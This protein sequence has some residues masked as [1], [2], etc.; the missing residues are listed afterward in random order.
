MAG[1]REGLLDRVCDHQT[2]APSAPSAPQTQRGRAR[3]PAARARGNRRSARSASAAQIGAGGRQRRRGRPSAAGR[4]SAKRSITPREATGRV[5]PTRPTRSPPRTASSAER[6][7]QHH[8]AIELG[9]L[10]QVGAEPHR[11]R[12]VEPYPQRL[13]RLPFALAHEGVRSRAPSGAS[14]CAK[15]VRRDKNGRNCQKVSPGPATAAARARH[16]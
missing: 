7:R 11:G 5:R 13:R 15:P 16:A 9:A 6:E 1:E 14:R 3:C 8:R 4:T 12:A 10:S 2:D